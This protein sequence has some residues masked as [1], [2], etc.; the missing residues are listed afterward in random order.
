[1][2]MSLA[3]HNKGWGTRFLDRPNMLSGLLLLYKSN[4]QVHVLMQMSWLC[5]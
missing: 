2:L 4:N 1:M 3:Q 5:C